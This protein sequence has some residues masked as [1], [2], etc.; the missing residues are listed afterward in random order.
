MLAAVSAGLAISAGAEVPDT[1]RTPIFRM[2]GIV[3]TASRTPEEIAKA[4]AAVTVVTAPELARRQ[5]RATA[6]VLR[7]ETGITVQKTNHNGGSPVIRGMMGNQILLLVDGIRLNN[8]IYRYGPNQYLNTIGAAGLKRIEVVRGPGSA[9]YGSDAMGGVVNAL[10]KEPRFSSSGLCLGGRAEGRWSSTDRGSLFGGEVSVAGSKIALAFGGTHKEVGD[11][12]AGRGFQRRDSSSQ[13]SPSSWREK[14]FDAKLALIPLM[15]HRLVA[16][17]QDVRQRNVEFYHTPD[18]L[19]PYQDRTLAYVK[20]T[21]ENPLSFLAQLEARASWQVQKEKWT[22]KKSDPDY[23]L[24]YGSANEVGTPGAS[25]RTQ[26]KPWK[27]VEFTLGVESYRD[28]VTS[29]GFRDSTVLTAGAVNR[30]SARGDY[31]NAV[32]ENRG[33]FF[34][35]RAQP[36]SKLALFS[37]IRYD[38]FKLSSSPDSL[39]VPFGIVQKNSALTGGGGMRWEIKGPLALAA[40]IATAFRAPNVDDV[41][42]FGPVERTWFEVPNPGL[43]PEKSA[44]VDYGLRWD[45]PALA[46]SLTFYHAGLRDLI[47][48]RPASYN[49]DTLYSGRRVQRR[50]NV[51]RARIDGLEAEVEVLLTNEVNFRGGLSSAY[52]QDLTAGVPLRRIPPLSGYVACQIAKPDGRLWAEA[53]ARLAGEQSRYAP[54]DRSDLDMQPAPGRYVTPGYAILNFRFGSKV[55]R[56]LEATLG[57]ENIANRNY[58]EHGS[59]VPASGT[60]VT[61]G[62]ALSGDR[63]F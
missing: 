37:G 17:L 13:V 26:T 6:E 28:K 15:K 32:L 47:D 14:T 50:E 48:R 3:V 38:R 33:G 27:S 49:G 12:T 25:F 54:G 35:S 62:L 36:F 29:S 43:K 61:L 11:F 46:L 55:T 40:N 4:P 23:S 21:W 8:A 19:D 22:R 53:T 31:S 60:N 7:E 2:R 9:Y 44:T 63:N 51:I 30:R 39:A 42:R 59:R 5:P 34:L 56:F 20:W 58:W 57:I 16:A 18:R 10:T 41:L 45:G 52:G 24:I 1:T